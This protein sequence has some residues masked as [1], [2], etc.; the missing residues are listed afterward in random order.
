MAK[1]ASGTALDTGHSLYPSLS[2][3]DAFL[4]GSGT[5]TA[6]SK[7]GNTGTLSSSGLWATDAD[8][9]VIRTVA[10]NV[11]QPIALASP[12]VLSASGGVSWSIAWRTK[13]AATSGSAAGT[14]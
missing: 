5:T 8:G 3:A 11:Q 2:F 7:N 6:D 4:E 13:M 14:T 10:N 1:P 9:P 12:V